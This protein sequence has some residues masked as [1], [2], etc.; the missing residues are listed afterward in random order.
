L[1]K[2]LVLI[3]FSTL[4]LSGCLGP[5]TTESKGRNTVSQEIEISPK[6]QNSRLESSSTISKEEAAENATKLYTTKEL[7]EYKPQIIKKESLN[8]NDLDSVAQ[9]SAYYFV[10]FM[11]DS[12]TA[13][14]FIDDMYKVLDDDFTSKLGSNKEEMA[15][16]LHIVQS[17]YYKNIPQSKVTSYFI[18]KPI[19]FYATA[20]ESLKIVYRRHVLENGD[21]VFFEMLFSQGK[22]G[23]K[24][25]EDTPTTNPYI[26]NEELGEEN[27]AQTNSTN[28]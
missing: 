24:L 25:V 18:S 6:E 2:K 27:N 8:I 9:Y 21:E 16:T 13:D 22:G 26:T 12:I 19:V 14:Q 20:N 11:K 7:E 23:W 15:K 17:S 28:T 4:L 1:Y 5:Y 10:E 3:T